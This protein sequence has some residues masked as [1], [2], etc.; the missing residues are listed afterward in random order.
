MRVP[1]R[2]K[3]ERHVEGFRVAEGLLHSAADRVAVVLGLDH[4]QGQVRPVVQQVVGPLL[5][6]AGGHLAPDL[7]AA[8]GEGVL[9]PDLRGPLPPR[10]LYRRGDEGVAYLRFVQAVLVHRCLRLRFNK[11]GDR[12]ASIL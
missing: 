2:R 9:T 8:G 10:L 6:A 4:G 11:I 5:P 12:S 7:D 3:R 1:V